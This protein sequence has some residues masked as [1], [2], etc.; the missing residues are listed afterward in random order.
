M[1]NSSAALS[2]VYL[3]FYFGN[4][5]FVAVRRAP[6]LNENDR[7]YFENFSQKNFRSIWGRKHYKISGR[8]EDENITFPILYFCSIYERQ[9]VNGRV[10]GM[11]SILTC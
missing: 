4:C 5:I 9:V 7:N 2:Y 3:P 1:S 11:E 8:F 6:F 10:F